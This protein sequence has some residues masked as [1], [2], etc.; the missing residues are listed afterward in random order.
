MNVPIKTRLE[1]LGLRLRS[2]LA[3]LRA[4][5]SPSGVLTKTDQGLFVSDP[6]DMIVGRVLRKYGS[7]EPAILDRLKAYLGPQGRALVVGAHIGTLAVPLSKCCAE[8]LVYEPNPKT[9]RLLT[10]NIGLN[11]VDNCRAFNLAAGEKE[12]EIAFLANTA[13]SGGS[14]RKPLVDSF[15]YTYDSPEV[16]NVPMVALDTHIENHAFDLIVMDIEGSEF[17]AL[18][19][20]PDILA[21]SRH[22]QMEY[23]ADHLDK[24]SAVSN[25]ELLCLLSPH[26]SRVRLQPDG[27]LVRRDD[28]LAFLD[29]LRA[30]EISGDLLFSK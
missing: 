3:A 13:N 26:F 7:Y 29:R 4:G 15:L 25:E 11:H 6:S 8:I 30:D 9:F 19:G 24:V 21:K 5:P 22:L 12:G 16:L 28:F 14:K 20:M 2:K 18:S 1:L 27:D 10:I 23:I 17:F